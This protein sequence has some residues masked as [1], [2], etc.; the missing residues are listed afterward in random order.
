M[1]KLQHVS[2]LKNG[3]KQSVMTAI[4]EAVFSGLTP[5]QVS[6]VLTELGYAPKLNTNELPA[7]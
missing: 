5:E 2:I 1:T 6:D 7:Y 3:L 4:E